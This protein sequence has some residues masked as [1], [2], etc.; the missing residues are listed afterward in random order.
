[1]RRIIPL[2]VA[3]I[4]SS[5]FCGCGELGLFRSVGHLPGVAPTDYAFYD[6]CGTSSQLYQFSLPQVESS[7]MVALGDMGFKVAGPPDHQPDGETCIKGHT[8]DGRSFKTT[9]KPQGNLTNVRIK[10]GPDSLGDY[11][12]SRDL[13]R[14]VALNLGTAMRAYT[15]VDSTL[16]RRLNFSTGIP[17]RAGSSPPIELKGEGLRPNIKQTRDEG[18]SNETP[19]EEMDADDEGLPTTPIPSFTPTRAYPNPPNMPYAPFPYTPFN[20]NPSQ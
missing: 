3:M 12:L 15:P 10:V 13:H 6:F 4:S 2:I 7:M 11:E 14:R 19:S 9:I 18:T 17:P 5:A 16:P 20:N 1:M 8:P